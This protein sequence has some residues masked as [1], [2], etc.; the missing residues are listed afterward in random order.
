MPLE[1]YIP[2]VT[3]KCKADKWNKTLA[4]LQNCLQAYES[5]KKKDFG[6]DSKQAPAVRSSLDALAAVCSSEDAQKTI[7]SLPGFTDAV[8]AEKGVWD[9]DRFKYKPQNVRIIGPLSGG[10]AGATFEA[11]ADVPET[12]GPKKVFKAEPKGYGHNLDKPMDEGKAPSVPGDMRMDEIGSRLSAR[13]VAS[14][15]I[16]KALG[17]G[18]LART[19]FASATVQDGDGHAQTRFG[20]LQDWTGG[21]SLNSLLKEEKSK[22]ALLA[23]YK[24]PAVFRQLQ[25]LQ[26]VDYV[27]GQTD[28]HADNIH[29]TKEKKVLG[30]DHDF[31]FGTGM[32]GIKP[33]MPMSSTKNK[34]LPKYIDKDV[35]EKLRTQDLGTKISPYLST[36]ELADTQ[37]RIKAVMDAVEAKKITVIADWSK[38]ASTDGLDAK[39]S[40]QYDEAARK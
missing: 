37:K 24:D 28:R 20:S 8:R 13:A 12:K 15:K 25:A 7:A 29:I 22:G 27:T 38:E 34:G 5:A 10:K 21:Q 40:Y 3:E 35:Y 32:L 14:W 39:N 19:R 36:A 18:V 1:D 9:N 4:A 23:D 6:E 16:D 11:Q 17:C 31:S 26:L 30:I 2:V 33:E